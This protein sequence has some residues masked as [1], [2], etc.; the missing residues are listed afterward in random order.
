MLKLLQYLLSAA[1]LQSPARL[2]GEGRRDERDGRNTALG[3]SI[4]IIVRAYFRL[5]PSRDLSVVVQA[6][7]NPPVVIGFACR[8]D[9]D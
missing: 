4:H 3:D 1:G 7:M 2:A 8:A 5:L 9:S 6:I